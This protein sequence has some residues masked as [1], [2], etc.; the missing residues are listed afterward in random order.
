MISL[1]CIDS[2]LLTNKNWYGR[3]QLAPFRKSEG[4]TIANAL[5]R[6]LLAEKSNFY[7]SWVDLYN[8]EI[9]YSVLTGMRESVFDILLNLKQIIFTSDVIMAQNIPTSNVNR[10]L[11]NNNKLENKF[12][13][14]TFTEKKRIEK[15]D[16]QSS[17]K[18]HIPVGQLSRFNTNWWQRNLKNQTKKGFNSN[19]NESILAGFG[20]MSKEKKKPQ[21]E[22]NFSD[23]L[24]RSVK[25]KTFYDN[26][27]T[28]WFMLKK[29]KITNQ[30]SFVKNKNFL[31][32]SNDFNNPIIIGYICVQGPATIY[33]KDIKLPK[34]LKCLNPDQFLVTL[35]DDGIFFFRF[36]IHYELNQPSLNVIPR[37]FPFFPSSLM[38][39]IQ[40]QNVFCKT[41]FSNINTIALPN[42]QRKLYEQNLP[43]ISL[44]PLS[45]DFFP[46][47][48]N[49]NKKLVSR[50]IQLSKKNK[51]KPVRRPIYGNIKKNNFPSW[52]NKLSFP[53]RQKYSLPEKKKTS[54]IFDERFINTIKSKKKYPQFLYPPLKTKAVNYLVLNLFRQIHLDNYF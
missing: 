5:R 54:S 27:L 39:L 16:Y 31:L 15:N 1:I 43:H 14:D 10:L 36:A 33:G 29:N 49:K 8:A 45:T 17:K 52:H 9:P 22:N 28:N 48:K 19:C 37:N 38:D 35:S 4:L 20:R 24:N 44:P 34:G 21:G 41:L 46:I 13:N 23:Y 25:A 2:K 30:N 18:N 26:P 53:V 42:P 6:T 40:N 7:I 50:T 47:K 12:H 51:K 32:N 11:N 3:F